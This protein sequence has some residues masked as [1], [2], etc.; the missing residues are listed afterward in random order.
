MRVKYLSLKKYFTPVMFDQFVYALLNFCVREFPK[1]SETQQPRKITVECSTYVRLLYHSLS[2][3]II[4]INFKYFLK[5]NVM[6]SA[7]LSMQ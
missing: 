7:L 2:V 3:G 6:M 4:I 1:K 5:V